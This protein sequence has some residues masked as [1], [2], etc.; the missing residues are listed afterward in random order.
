[1]NKQ[2]TRQRKRARHGLCSSTGQRSRSK[3]KSLHAVAPQ[4]QIVK[5]VE[6]IELREQSAPQQD[7]T[8]QIEHR[9][10]LKQNSRHN[11]YEDGSRLEVKCRI[12][13]RAHRWSRFFKSLLKNEV[14]L[15]L[16]PHRSAPLTTAGILPWLS[17]CSKNSL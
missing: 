15:T 6:G 17:D 12:L 7:G 8:E 11:P 1:M 5:N 4:A 16:L 10:R 9:R 2:S 3:V 13:A 14:A